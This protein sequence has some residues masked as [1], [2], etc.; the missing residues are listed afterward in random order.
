MASFTAPRP[1]GEHLLC[2]KRN[3]STQV[4]QCRGRRDDLDN[5]RSGSR[6][7]SRNSA[8]LLRASTPK[9]TTIAANLKGMA[10][11]T[12][13]TGGIPKAYCD[14]IFRVRDSIVGMAGGNAYT[15]RWLEWFRREMPPVESML[16][17]DNS[18]D[19]KQ[20]V[21]LVL[22][23]KGIWMYTNM[24]DPDLLHNKYYAIGT[25]SQAACEAMKRGDTPKQAVRCAMKWDE[26][27]GGKVTELLLIKPAKERKRGYKTN[28]KTGVT[29][30]TGR[31][32]K[33][34]DNK[35]SRRSTG[36]NNEA[37]GASPPSSAGQGPKAV[38]GDSKAVT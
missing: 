22:D 20:F 38:P 26:G 34:S 12:L 36:A 14:K 27:T 3:W 17:I 21:A 4:R 23:E 19:E 37:V 31:E 2:W 7:S 18:D 13:V 16:E 15:T 25:G 6:G 28:P 8:L 24:C 10:A 29:R 11:D 35:R 32:S 33:V 30:S 9:M 1:R 5:R